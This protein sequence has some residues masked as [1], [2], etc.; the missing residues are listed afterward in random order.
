MIESNDWV[1]ARENFRAAAGR[2][3]YALPKLA[4]RLLFM[5]ASL[6]A[7]PAA[8]GPARAGTLGLRLALRNNSGQVGCLLFNSE[9]GYPKDPKAAI[10]RKWCSIANLESVCRFDPI[11]AG[12]YAVACF[13]DENKNGRLDTG[14][15]GIPSEGT[16]A[17]NNAKGF[18][19][20]PSFERA[21]FS[22]TGNATELRLTM[23]Y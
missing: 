11:P 7:A 14:L 22:F 1:P 23:A 4:S 21:R 2:L 10:Q 8:A 17:S 16:V 18:M 12:T 13:H 5:G 20:P 3:A 6:A 9:R 19:G 15:F